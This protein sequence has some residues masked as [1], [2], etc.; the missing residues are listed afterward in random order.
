MSGI[1]RTGKNIVCAHLRMEIHGTGKNVKRL[2]REKMVT[3]EGEEVESEVVLV[4]M[5]RWK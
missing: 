2:E 4:M 1:L 3:A 5:V